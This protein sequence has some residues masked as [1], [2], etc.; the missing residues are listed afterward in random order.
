M[1]LRNT[2]PRTP[3]PER[4]ETRGRAAAAAFIVVT[5]VAVLTVVFL[6]GYSAMIAS[7]STQNPGNAVPAGDLAVSANDPYVQ[8]LNPD[9]KAPPPAERLPVGEDELVVS[10]TFD[11]GFSSQMTAASTLDQ[12]GFRGTFYINSG[13]VGKP[14]HLSLEQ[15][16]AL[17]DAG[18]E[19]GGHSVSHPNLPTL[20]PAE[21]L[22]EIC[23]DRATL[24]GWGFTVRNF[25]Y[26]FAATDAVTRQAAMNCGYN[27]ARSLGDVRNRFGCPDCPIAET[28]PPRI[29]D[30]TAA[31][32]NVTNE[33]TLDDLKDAVQRPQLTGGW[34]QLT[35]HKLCTTD[36]DRISI[37][38]SIFEEFLLWLEERTENSNIVVRSVEQVI[39]G[40]VQPLAA[41]TATA[42]DDGGLNLKNPSVERL[43]RSTTELP[44]NVARRGR[45]PECWTPSSTGDHQV[46]VSVVSPGHRGENA[47]VLEVD[48]YVD[49]EA[50]MVQTQDLGSCAPPVTAAK[51]YE[52][53]AWYT[54]TATTQ[55]S[56]AYRL[57]RGIW[58]YW[59]SSPTFPATQEYAEASWTTPPIPKGATAISF[60][61]ALQQNGE[62]I[63]DDYT[64]RDATSQPT[65]ETRE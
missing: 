43:V 24:T 10:L 50:K 34:I 38:E 28:I 39:G 52:L 22:R 7:P 32:S 18:H 53:R 6:R 54:S 21:A 17:A 4:K 47:L 9:Y 45:L 61:L 48:E 44:D 37:Q 15:V 59:T 41:E 35:F 29:A 63:T 42:G 12:H 27:T 60:G 46:K 11:D 2:G 23:L 51:S 65:N 16:R 25:A 62:L 55:F 5:L 64:L 58:A 3:S 49:G 40:P 20:A 1:E 13:S 19:I 56:V 31:P 33:W 8:N 14:G 30:Y 57:E 36:C 26:P